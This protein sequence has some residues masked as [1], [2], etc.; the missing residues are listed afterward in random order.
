[1]IKIAPSILAA[2]FT[3]LG[4][5]LDTIRSADQVHFDV[6]DGVFVPNISFGL[7]VL[8]AVR[9]YTDMHL[10]AHLMITSPVRYVERFC[11]AG[12]DTVIIHAEADTEERILEAL[13]I[14]KGCGKRAGISLKPGT[15]AS[16]V[17]PYLESVDEILCMTV[18]PGF[19]G[20][21]FRADMLPKITLL[22]D[23]AVFTGREIDISVDGGINLKTAKRAAKAGAN[24]FVNGTGVFTSPDREQYIQEFKESLKNVRAVPVSPEAKD[25]E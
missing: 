17:R 14:I 25:A 10:N 16:A 9:S 7:P 5:E 22:R 20:Q 11:S 1:M 21:S 3:C 24:L 6:M 15:P 4:K 12:A 8:E 13:K 18:E 19:G 2:D 23:M